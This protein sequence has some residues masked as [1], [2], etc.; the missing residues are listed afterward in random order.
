MHQET[1]NFAALKASCFAASKRSV[2]R[3]NE[4]WRAHGIDARAEMSADGEITSRIDVR[5]HLPSDARQGQVA[6]RSAPG[7]AGIARGSFTKGNAA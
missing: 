2:D 6:A 1:T 5:R 4:F 7:K 3:I